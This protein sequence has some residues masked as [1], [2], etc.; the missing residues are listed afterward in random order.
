[1]IE[2]MPPSMNGVSMKVLSQL[3]REESSIELDDRLSGV[4]DELDHLKKERKRLDDHIAKIQG[5]IISEL[6]TS[7]S[8]SLSD[9]TLVTYKQTKRKAY[10]REVP[11]STFRTLRI[12]R[13]KA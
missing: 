3:P 9:G 7:D 6:N 4:I 2:D 13:G 12:K 1:M 11:E 10:T 8:G 5:V